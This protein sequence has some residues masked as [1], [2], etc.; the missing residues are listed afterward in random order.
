MRTLKLAGLHSDSCTGGGRGRAT[1]KKGDFTAVSRVLFPLG[2]R[3]AS[4]LVELIVEQSQSGE[5]LGGEH[6]PTQAEQRERYQSNGPA[7]RGH[8]ALHA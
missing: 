4:L 8:V 2:Q 3:A 1:A 5:I 6:R 7:S